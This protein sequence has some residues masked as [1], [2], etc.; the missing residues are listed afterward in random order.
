MPLRGQGLFAPL[1]QMKKLRLRGVNRCSQGLESRSTAAL[2]LS[3]TEVRKQAWTRKTG[4]TAE[5]LCVQGVLSW[6]KDPPAAGLTW[7]GLG[8][9]CQEGSGKVPRAG[10]VDV[11]W[12]GL[13]RGPDR[14]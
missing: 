8:P 14:T 9:T 13:S 12:P 11:P 5:P 2:Q 7:K 6:G 10:P 4:F 3:L 1:L